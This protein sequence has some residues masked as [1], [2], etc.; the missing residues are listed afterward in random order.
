MAGRAAL[1]PLA[2]A[3]AGAQPLHLLH[4]SR[5]D[6]G[7]RARRDRADHRAV[8][9]E[10]F[11][12]RAPQ[13][14]SRRCVAC[15]S[16]GFRRPPDELATGF[17][18]GAAEPR[19]AGCGALRA[20]AGDA[21]ARRRGPRHPGPRRVARRRGD[22]GRLRPLHA[23][24]QPRCARPRSLRHRAR[25]R[26][27]PCFARAGRRKGHADRAPGPG[28][29]CRGLAAPEAIHRGRHL[30]SRHVRIRFRPGADPHGRRP[31]ALSYG[32]RGFRAADQGRRPV[33]RATRRS[34]TGQRHGRPA[35]DPRLDDEPRQLLPGSGAREEDDGDHP[36]PDRRGRGLQHRVDAGD[37][38]A[39]E[40]RRH[41]DPAHAR[42]VAIVGDG[43]LRAAGHGDR[44]GRPDHRH[45]RRH[46]AGEQPRRG[47]SV[48]RAAARHHA[49][50][51]GG[52]LHHR[53][54]LDGAG[55]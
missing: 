17:R 8:G 13:P 16:D 9:D 34:R 15:R 40:I 33:R 10:R 48:S 1:H 24:R 21:F 32:G 39:G 5:V 50:E 46:R 30:R 41:R 3:G 53:H 27:G 45:R 51:Q 25:A 26:T 52:V 11:P 36:V 37:G 55:E 12:G 14:D 23:G 4:L 18:A 20:G 35:G 49:V 2:Q 22:G 43:D 31:G 38:G 47:H 6:G 19:G 54:A 42:C 28:D 7:H 29:A 44:R